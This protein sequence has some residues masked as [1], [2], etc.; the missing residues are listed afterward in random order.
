M[1]DSPTNPATGDAVF[2]GSLHD[3]IWVI[4]AHGELDRECGD[5][6]RQ[7]FAAAATIAC[8]RVVV[9]ASA[10][11]FLDAGGLRHLL[12]VASECSVQ[13]WLRSPSRPVRRII[14]LAGLAGEALGDHP[15]DP[16]F[17]E[18]QLA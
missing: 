11:T 10:V 15:D 14:Q 1:R 4:T 2:A 9:D 6:L 8:D 12:T 18:V 5:G 7:Q 3:R 17:D 16:R 13:V